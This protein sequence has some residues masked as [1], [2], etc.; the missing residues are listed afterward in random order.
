[1][2]VSFLQNSIFQTTADYL[3]RN[4]LVI[5]ASFDDRNVGTLKGIWIQP[6]SR[7]DWTLQKV[8]LYYSQEK[9]IFS[10]DVLFKRYRHWHRSGDRLYRTLVEV[11]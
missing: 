3:L 5:K 2:E 1:M 9:Y 6:V 10:S 8:M 4:Q 7:V 11:F